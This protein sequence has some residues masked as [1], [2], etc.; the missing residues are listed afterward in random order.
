MTLCEIEKQKRDRKPKV[1]EIE[2]DRTEICEIDRSIL[3]DDAISN[4]YEEN[5]VQDIL[6][7]LM[8]LVA[9]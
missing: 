8:I 9:E 4:G 5:V 2:I 6:I 1:A 3:P 7:K